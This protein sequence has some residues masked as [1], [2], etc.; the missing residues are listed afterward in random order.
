MPATLVLTNGQIHT[1]DSAR[2]R[3]SAVALRDD[4]I[5]AVGDDDEMKALLGTG[6]EWIDLDS[7]AVTPGLVDAHV[8]FQW[9]ALNLQRIDLFEVPTLEEALRRVQAAAAEMEGDGWLQ[10]RGWT[11][12]VWP[13]RAFPTAA[14]LDRVAPHLP[15]YLIHKSGHAAWANSRALKLAGITTETPDPEGGQIGRD[16]QGRP[17]GVLFETAMDLV[18]EQIPE[19]T[20]ANVADAMRAAQEECWRVGLTGLHDFD[21]RTSFQ[22]LQTLHGDGELGLRVVKNI[23][24]RLLEHAVGLG[25]RSGFGDEWLRTGGIKIFAD[26]AL[27]PRTAYM[28]EPYEGEPDNRGIAVTDKEEMM[29]IAGEASANG[30]S[31]TIHAIGD[32]ANH[33]VLD[34]YEAVREAE[35]REGRPRLRHRIEHV[36]V[37]H[38]ADKERLAELDVIASMQPSHATADMEMADRYWGDR[39]RYSY[40][41][42]TMLESG[43]TVVFGSDAPIE[44]IA[45]LPGLYAAVARR[46][47]DGAPGPEGWYPEQRLTLTE[48]VHAFTRAAAFTSGQEARQGSITPGCLADLTIFDRDIFS[49]PA[50][51]LLETE[52]AGTIVGGTFKYRTL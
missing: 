51:A 47:P 5:M 3:V 10:G 39:A 30:L 20:A 14:D 4:G 45:P 29:A 28:I 19:S 38:P 34:V 37:I 8:H 43:A 15:V 1:M 7:R 9:W 25:L 42:R 32:R 12:D 26:G 24:A 33:D 17:T 52:I 6:G 11:Q 23:P 16:E 48:A 21:G 36:Q 18:S 46:R 2:P 50:E 40:A 31:V 44:S 35:E 22:A 41:W 13:S 49:A 27:G